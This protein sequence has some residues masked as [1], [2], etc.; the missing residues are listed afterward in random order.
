M[1]AGIL[2][3]IDGITNQFADQKGTDKA[4]DYCKILPEKFKTDCYNRVGVWVQLL[5]PGN[6]EQECSKA[7]TN[8]F[9]TCIIA[10]LENVK[11]L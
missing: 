2:L 11:I 9:E 7:E 3:N 5:H 10:N 1:H 4:M 8:Y 6:E